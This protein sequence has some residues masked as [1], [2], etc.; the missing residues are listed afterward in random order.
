MQ[1][2][3]FLLYLM[4]SLLLGGCASQPQVQI[5]QVWKDPAYRGHP[6]RIMVIGMSK[7]PL[8]RRIFEDEFVAQL[9]AQGA[10]A[11]ASYTF[12]PDARQDNQAALARV[13]EEQVPDTLLIT[14]VVSKRSV[15][16]VMPGTVYYRP[17]YYGKWRDYYRYGYDTVVTPGYVSKAEYALLETNLYDTRTDNLIWAASYEIDLSGMSQ[18]Y[19][20]PYVASMVE[21]L[22]E[23]GLLRP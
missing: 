6:H 19:I 15:K 1:A 20:K 18:K 11:L 2:G 9:R 13:V 16:T 12:L 8:N 3:R 23:Q 14:R 10:D 4:F 5:K 7:E 17:A 22:L 21:T